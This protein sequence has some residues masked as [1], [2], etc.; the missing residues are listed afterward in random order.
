[1]DIGGKLSTINATLEGFR[2]RVE[3]RLAVAQWVATVSVPIIV[4]LVGWA[5]LTLPTAKA[6]R[7][8]VQ[9]HLPPSEVL[10]CLPER[11]LW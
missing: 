5:F 2:G 9:R 1:V 11:F 8:S 4:A 3:T 7:F 6:G 10:Q